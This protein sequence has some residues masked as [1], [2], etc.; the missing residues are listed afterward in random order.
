MQHFYTF[1]KR[2]KTLEMWHW[3]KKGERPKV[4]NYFCTVI[5]LYCL[6]LSLILHCNINQKFIFQIFRFF[7]SLFHQTLTTVFH[8]AWNDLTFFISRPNLSLAKQKKVWSDT[9]KLQSKYHYEK[10]FEI[11]HKAKIVFSSIKTSDL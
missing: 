11:N 3:T 1:W 5:F 7:S 8:P 4:T 9:M 6:T 2:Q 10:G